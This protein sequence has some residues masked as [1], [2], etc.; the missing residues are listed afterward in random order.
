M[1]VAR[2]TAGRYVVNGAEFEMTCLGRPRIFRIVGVD[3]APMAAA[4]ACPASETIGEADAP[5]PANEMD[6][7]TQ[8]YARGDSAVATLCT[9]II[10]CWRTSEKCVWC[11]PA[12]WGR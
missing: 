5:Q 3:P 6:E 9:L 12:A 10:R 11:F 4:E 7:L 1:V 2:L 8:G